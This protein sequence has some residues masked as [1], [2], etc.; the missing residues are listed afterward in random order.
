MNLKL[1]DGKLDSK[2][3]IS[4]EVNGSLFSILSRYDKNI[5]VSINRVDGINT[6]TLFLPRD[7]SSR[8]L[9]LSQI[10]EI[11]EDTNDAFIRINIKL[12]AKS[13][14]NLLR[15]VIGETSVLVKQI[16]FRNS[17]INM[18][19]FFHSSRSDK[20]T[21]VLNILEERSTGFKITYFGPSLSLSAELNDLSLSED[22]TVVQVSTNI[23][24]H[25]PRIQ[26]IARTHPD[27]IFIPELRSRSS[28]GVRTLVFSPSPIENNT[29][30]EISK[31]SMIYEFF[32]WEKL[33]EISRIDVETQNVPLAGAVYWVR[34]DRLVDTTLIS[35][36]LA[37]KYVR[38]YMT[39]KGTDGNLSQILEFYYRLGSKVWQ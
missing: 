6:L 17:E 26:N 2:C 3:I 8:S 22:I 5:S 10:V 24:S 14:I 18:E 21:E 4:L 38:N 32:V 23:S 28:K 20:I 16:Y 19:F 37:Q 36:P 12:D 11:H 13:E 15:K 30:T 9:P 29:F 39:L 31:P 7:D 34:G 27:A 1:F 35:T 25:S 33:L